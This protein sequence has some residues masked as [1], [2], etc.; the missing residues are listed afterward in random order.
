M[1]L[2]SIA[3]LIKGVLLLKKD[4]LV[5]RDV[6]AEI[7]TVIDGMTE[8]VVAV[9]IGIDQIV[10]SRIITVASVTTDIENITRVHPTVGL[11]TDVIL[12]DQDIMNKCCWW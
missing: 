8:T 12:T 7:M 6:R 9:E 2:W 11:I 1:N 3:S 10:E 4:G 5:N